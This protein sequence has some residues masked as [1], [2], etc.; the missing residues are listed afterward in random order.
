L[1]HLSENLKEFVLDPDSV[2]FLIEAYGKYATWKVTKQIE[3][4]QA[5]EKSQKDEQAK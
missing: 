1:K 4:M 5:I 2:S 3:D